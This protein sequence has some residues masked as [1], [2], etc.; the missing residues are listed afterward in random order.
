MNSKIKKIIFLIIPSII[1]SFCLIGTAKAGSGDNVFGWAWSENIGW[2]SFNNTSAG[3]AT[4]YGVHIC[5]N[6]IDP[7]CPGVAAPKVG[8]FTGY[9]WSENIGWIAFA[10]FDGDGDVDAADRNIAGA[11]CAPNCQTSVDEGGNV[12]GWA[13]ALVFG[14]GWDGWI[15]LRGQTTETLPKS[16]GV[17]IDFSSNPSDF[18]GWAWGDAVV[19]WVDFNTLRAEGVVSTLDNGNQNCSGNCS[20]LT[21]LELDS[22]G[23]PVIAYYI[24][25][26][27]KGYIKLIHCNDA[28]CLGNDEH[29][30]IV[31]DQT[32]DWRNHDYENWSVDLELDKNGNPVIAYH[33]WTP[34]EDL[35]LVRCDDPNCEGGNETINTVDSALDVGSW[36]VS[37]KLNYNDNPTLGYPVISY[38]KDSGDDSK[39]VHCNDPYCGPANGVESP[40]FLDTEAIGSGSLQ[41]DTSGNPVIVYSSSTYSKVIHCNNPSCASKQVNNLKNPA[42]DSCT[43]YGMPSLQ[44]SPSS[45]FPVV[46]CQRN[47]LWLYLCNDVNCAGSNETA[48]LIESGNFGPYTSLALDAGIPVIAYRA[49]SGA[50]GDI[51]LAR[52][53]DVNC[54]SFE[55]NTIDNPYYDVGRGISMQLDSS[56]WPIISYWDLDHNA[57]KFAH[58]D[59][60]KCD[61]S[62]ISNYKVK[63]SFSFHQLPYVEPGSAIVSGQSYCGFSSGRGQVSLQWKYQNQEADNQTE[64]QVQVTNSTDPNFNSPFINCFYPETGVGPGQIGTSALTVSLSPTAGCANFEIGYGGSY[65]WRLKVK[66][67]S[68]WSADWATGTSFVTPVHA[69]PAPAFI[70][71]PSRPKANT[72]VEFDDNSACYSAPC[73]SY[74]WNFGNGQYSS[75]STDTTIYTSTGLKTVSLTVKD[76]SNYQCST[77]TSITIGLAVPQWQEI[78][79]IMWLRRILASIFIFAK[80]F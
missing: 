17:S 26:G 72:I 22:N 4:N 45:G 52:C 10:D 8:K 76:G 34:Q 19:G 42:G 21:S 62:G 43:V 75:N 32:G 68:D 29:I 20:S 50:G 15:N 25:N 78:A 11:P 12:S 74:S 61:P 16:Y 31:T 38:W 48:I 69:Y 63:T 79:P 40:I 58:C 64:Y 46:S 54:S 57:L 24:D 65:L 71:F 56:G 23:Y 33:K 70:Y 1:F 35:M 28:Y 2:I 13:R 39:F 7:L 30:N 14:D 6:D 73:S 77:S 80:A 44:L 37:M 18:S 51:K 47:G 55:T 66:D 36:G 3:G 60:E 41:L 27:T 59:D 49:G 5:K 67:S 9:A 53:N